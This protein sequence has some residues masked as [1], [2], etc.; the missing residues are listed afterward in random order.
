MPPRSYA[1]PEGFR[2]ALETRVRAAAG[3]S[4][5]GRF[6]QVLVYDRLLARVFQHLGDRVVAKGG[7]VLEL[8]LER[9]RTTR[10]VD[11]QLARERPPRHRSP[12]PGR[13]TRCRSTPCGPPGDVRVSQD[14]AAS[15]IAACAAL[16]LGTRIRTN[17]PRGRASLAN[18]RG[19]ARR[20]TSLHRPRAVGRDR[21]VGARTME[22]VVGAKI[23]RSLGARG[24]CCTHHAPDSF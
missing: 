2:Q 19:A 11:I 23:S 21:N 18:A 15:I 5:M 14:A 16:E 3:S 22:L 10:D 13:K 1:T 8:R 4:G 7:V 17:G 20:R 12:G 24:D 9:A 6:R